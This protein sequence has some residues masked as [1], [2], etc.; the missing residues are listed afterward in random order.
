MTTMYS[1]PALPETWAATALPETVTTKGGVVFDPRPD[2]WEYRDGLKRVYLDFTELPVTEELLNS[3]KATLTWYAA[4][5]APAYLISVFTEFYSFAEDVY[6]LT[7]R[8]LAGITGTRE[9]AIRMRQ[10]ETQTLLDN[11][12]EAVEDGEFVAN[13]WVAHQSLTLQ[14]LDQLCAILDDPSVP[15]GAIIQPAGVVSASRLEQAAQQRALRAEA[16]QLPAPTST[17]SETV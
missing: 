10:K 7:D 11:A 8:P 9:Q 17:E 12:K 6:D 13:R 15:D 5:R 4:N 14:R 2:V 3:F 16:L 1:K